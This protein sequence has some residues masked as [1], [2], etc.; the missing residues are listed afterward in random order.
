[1]RFQLS[2]RGLRQALRQLA[3]QDPR[4]HA[5]VQRWGYPKE[6]RRPE[7]FAT[8]VR[9]L[10][11]QQLS[12]RAAATIYERLHGC[13]GV[14]ADAFD[15]PRLSRARVP[16]LRK[17][18]LSERKA[19]SLRDLARS[20]LTGALQLEAF[21]EMPDE[22]VVSQI[23]AVKGFGPWSAHMYLIFSLGR[24]NVWP[25]DDLGVRKGLQSLLALDDCP[26][27]KLTATLGEAYAPHRSSLALLC[28]HVKNNPAL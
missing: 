24:P 16:T 26:S 10:T 14:E 23:A 9:A 5:A 3:E 27:A 21:A 15:V 8:L 2:A 22:A 25:V 18:G 7:G 28:W 4:V 11:G 20:T 1:M 19:E 6:R 13:F 17:L 12:V